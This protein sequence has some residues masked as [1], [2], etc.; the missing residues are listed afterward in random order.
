MTLQAYVTVL[1]ERWRAVLLAL[2]VTVALAVLITAITPKTYRTS[3]QVYVGPNADAAGAV[4]DSFNQQ[5]AVQA[6]VSTFAEL[7]NAPEIT[8]RVQRDLE[9]GVDLSLAALRSRISADAPAQQSIIDV[10]AVDGSAEVA[11][12]IA[13]SAAAAFI[14]YVQRLKTPADGSV[15]TVKLT[16]TSVAAAPAAPQSP[17]AVLNVALGVLLGLLGGIA[18]AVVRDVLDNRVKSADALARIAGKPSLAVVV[19]DPSADRRPVASGNARA[20][21]FRQLRANLQFANLDS[22]PRVIAVCSSLPAEGKTLTAVNLAS[23]L[24]ET[25]FTVCLV[26]ADLR[27][28]TAAALLGLPGRIGL[29]NVLIKQIGLEDA[30]QSASSNLYLLASG[31]TPPNPS[32]VLAS[33]TVREVI[34]SLLDRFDYVILDTAPLLPVADGSEVAALADGCLLVSRHKV[35][36]EPQ[37]TR[38]VGVLRNVDA[39]LLGVVLN[40]VPERRRRSTDYDYTAFTGGAAD[41]EPS[42]GGRRGRRPRAG[43]AGARRRGAVSD[44]MA[45]T[46]AETE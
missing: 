46:T 25:G 37:V 23:V 11:A 16:A 3:V 38:A 28:P 12:K 14:D 45:A 30:L 29:T 1:R 33:S 17:D 5:A 24:A 32:E 34:R 7:I 9:P 43:F 22:H 41:A 6:Q 31:P 8:A 36:T 18:L 10:N 44:P 39:T 40:R 21:S 26:D 42:T 27:R 4:V 13:N 20:E 19:D 15:P 2:F 35:S